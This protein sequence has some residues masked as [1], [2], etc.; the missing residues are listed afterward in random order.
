MTWWA[1]CRESGWRARVEAREPVRMWILNDGTRCLLRI[2][3]SFELRLMRHDLLLRRGEYPDLSTARHA[4]QQWR[5][6]YEID[7]GARWD[8]SPRSR[9]PECG[10]DAFVECDDNGDNRWF[11]CPSCGDVWVC[12][13]CADRE[14][15]SG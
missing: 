4:A 10:D 5:L 7:R 11:V 15:S 3:G 14:A 1:L 13:D 9:C 2:S 12:S 8:P 6:D